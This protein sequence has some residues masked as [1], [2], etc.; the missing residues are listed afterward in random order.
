M[1]PKNGTVL[2]PLFVRVVPRLR[3]TPSNSTVGW[4]DGGDLDQGCKHRLLSGLAIS[5][6]H[7]WKPIVEEGWGSLCV[8]H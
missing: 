4:S 3:Q 2:T 1:V 8:L 5:F 6:S 7:F